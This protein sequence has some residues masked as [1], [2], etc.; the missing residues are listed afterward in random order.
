M[1]HVGCYFTS[2][3]VNMF[4]REYHKN[5]CEYGY[6]R[7]IQD[8]Q[9]EHK[10]LCLACSLVSLLTLTRISTFETDLNVHIHNINISTWKP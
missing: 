2:E 3:V 5:I 7:Y 8:H 10:L 1:I 4:H 6:S 9:C